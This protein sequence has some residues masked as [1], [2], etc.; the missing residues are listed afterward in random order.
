[1]DTNEIKMSFKPNESALKRMAALFLDEF[2]G[3]GGA[4]DDDIE[5]VAL[6]LATGEFEVVLRTD[7]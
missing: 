3:C 1:M 2:M 7:D 6:N 5:S 4:T